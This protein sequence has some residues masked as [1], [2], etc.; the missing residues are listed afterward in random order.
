MRERFDWHLMGVNIGSATGWDMQDTFA[1]VIYNFIP[2]DV[3]LKFV[4]E[5]KSGD[6]ITVD[7][8]AGTVATFDDIGNETL[9]TCDWSVFNKQGGPGW[10]VGSEESVDD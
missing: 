5:V 9:L 8:E 3:G 1:I 4:P 2:N 10:Q 6:D 7:W